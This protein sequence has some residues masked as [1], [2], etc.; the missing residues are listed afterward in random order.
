MKSILGTTDRTMQKIKKSQR[1]DVMCI[2]KLSLYTVLIIQYGSLLNTNYGACFWLIVSAV[3]RVD[4]IFKHGLMCRRKSSCAGVSK[5]AHSA[6]LPPCRCL[7]RF[8]LWTNHFEML[9]TL[10]NV[11]G[12]LC[13]LNGRYICLLWVWPTARHCSCW[14]PRS[15]RGCG[16]TKMSHSQEYCTV[17]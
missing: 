9:K 15:C 2:R 16:S 3:N 11:A 7:F 8:V 1:S 10:W 4:W 17:M 5:L 6:E 12:L 13:L 14:A